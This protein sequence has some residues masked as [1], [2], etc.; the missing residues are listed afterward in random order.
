MTTLIKIKRDS[1]KKNP[2]AGRDSVQI[3]MPWQVTFETNM[4]K[5]ELP[6]WLQGNITEW[7]IGTDHSL[8]K[9][10]LGVVDDR[11]MEYAYSV[12]KDGNRF[13]IEAK[14]DIQTIRSITPEPKYNYKYKNTK[15]KCNHCQQMIPVNDIKKDVYEG[16]FDVCPKC[17]DGDTFDY[18]YEQIEDAIRKE[19]AIKEINKP[20]TINQ[21]YDDKT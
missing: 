6:E 18:K 16:I 19:E 20:H 4:T 15:V 8:T 21:Q 7:S 1:I 3:P 11:V 2:N 5:D 13:S 17:G 9:G 14:R 10:W 12:I